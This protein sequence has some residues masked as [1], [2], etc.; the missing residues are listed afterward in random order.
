MLLK[1]S[2]ENYPP[3]AFSYQMVSEIHNQFLCCILLSLALK[4]F[5]KKW[6]KQTNKQI[7]KQNNKTKGQNM[8][9]IFLLE[10]DRLK[11]RFRSN[12][13]AAAMLLRSDERENRGHNC[14]YW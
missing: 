14:A 3:S 7:Q 5:S 12:T 13:R 9:F 1:L 8:A 6:N 11:Y 4:E 2:S 10:R